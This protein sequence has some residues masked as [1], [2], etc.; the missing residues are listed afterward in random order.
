MTHVCTRK[1]FVAGADIKEM[2][3]R[4]FSQNINEDFL[5]HWSFLTLIRKPIIAAVNGFAVTKAT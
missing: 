1:W 2:S 5:S 3:E 4:S